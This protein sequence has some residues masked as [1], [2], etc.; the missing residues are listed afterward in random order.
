[1]EG[2]S[3]V[4]FERG[5][6]MVTKVSK[7]VREALLNSTNLEEYRAAGGNESSAVNQRIVGD[8]VHREVVCCISS[9]V[10]A[11][12]KVASECHSEDF[13]Y[14]ELLNLCERRADNSERIDE[15]VERLEEIDDEV[16]DLRDEIDGDEGVTK[17][18]VAQIEKEVVALEFEQSKLE[19]EKQE[20]EDDQENPSEVYEH[21][22]VSNFFA[23]RL[24]EHGEVTGDLLDFKVWGRCCTGQAILLDYVVCAI[25]AEMQIL[26]GQRNDWSKQ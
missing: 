13:D 18:R 9:T 5:I 4:L 21:W 1:V 26:E 10:S 3:V 24:A 15:I 25:A 22:A 11:L 20:L 6:G 8:L 19:D 14:D 17:R 16:S 2:V 23:R 7:K 12:L